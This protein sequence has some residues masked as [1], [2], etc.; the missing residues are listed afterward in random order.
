MRKLFSESIDLAALRKMVQSNYD[1]SGVPIG[2]IDAVS[3]EVYAGAGWQRICTDYH[4]KHPETLALCVESDTEISGKIKRGESLA[5][6]CK[7]GLWDIGIP[8]MSEGEH[9]VTIFLGQ[10]RYEDEIIDENLFKENARRYEFPIEEYLAA[11]KEVPVFTREKVE[12]IISYNKSFA[13]FLSSQIADKIKYKREAQ[14][15]KEA[16]SMHSDLFHN[17]TV[18]VVYQDKSGGIINANKA[19]QEILGLSLEQMQGRSSVDPR[20]QTIY[21]DGSAFPGEKHP[22]MVALKTGK[23]VN[24][25]V[26]GVFNPKDNKNHWLLVNSTPQF[27]ENTLEPYQV[28]T[29]FIDI[30]ERIIAEKNL[31][32]LNDTLENQ[33]EERTKQLSEKV[34]A[35]ELSENNF[36]K[37]V[38]NSP[39]ILYRFSG[40]KGGFFV[41]KRVETVLGYPA[42]Y[43]MDHPLIWSQSIH[44]EDKHLVDDAIEQAKKGRPFDIEYR[45]KDKEER[46]HW[47]RDRSI[48]VTTVGEE[49]TIEGLAADITERKSNEI[50]LRDI[51][52]KLEMANKLG[53][54]GWWEYD[55][56]NDS[57][58]WPEETYALYGLDPQKIELDYDRMMACI[59]PEY[60][61]YHNEQ[62]ERI[63]KDG[64]AEFIYPVL[65]PN[66]E[67]RWIWAKGEAEYDRE[68]RPISLF[69]TLQD[70]TERIRI[71]HKLRMQAQIIEQVHDSVI[72]VDLEGHIIAWNKG[73]EN[74]FQYSPDEVIGNHVSMVYPKEY[75]SKLEG[76]IIPDLLAEG[77]LE[78]E[79]NLLRKNGSLFYGLVSLSVLRNEE[80][81]VYGMVGYTIDISRRKEVEQKLQESETKFKTLFN[82]VAIPLCYVDDNGVI[83]DFNTKF[84]QVFGYTKSDIPTLEEWWEFAYPD[85]EYRKWVVGTWEKAV[86]DARLKNTDI[87]SV[88]YNVTCKNGDVRNVVISGTT[89]ENYFL[90]TFI[91]ITDRNKTLQEL[92]RSNKELEQFAY[93]A[94]HDLQEPMRTVIGFLQLLQSRHENQ[95]DGKA[96]H[97]IDRSIKA[98]HRMQRLITD[99]LTYSRTNTK[100]LTC[101][102]TDL[103]QV[104]FQVEE[105][106]KAIIKEKKVVLKYCELPCVYADKNQLESLFQ[107]LILNGIKY[108]QSATPEIEIGFQDKGETQLFYVKDNGIGISP[109]SHDKIFE[110]FHRLHSQKEYSGTGLGLALCKRI[111][112]R[113]GGK[114]WVK[115]EPGN[116]STFYF[117]IKGDN[118][119]NE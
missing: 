23:S 49:F 77:S 27:K 8:V 112:E 28:F 118:G 99:L 58:I 33:V 30:T 78:Y 41:S 13:E 67:K 114:I 96:L 53:K 22:S 20:W 69:G 61:D 116:G 104:I 109:K 19:S 89:L 39:E 5:Y 111:V 32:Q 97:Y 105:N 48:G 60:H 73:S 55:V 72:S 66:Q 16:E 14:Q 92:S 7:N 57:V 25:V 71:E 119:F 65:L 115:S 26:M 82:I 54:S 91:D 94:S 43:L 90:A 76:E 100:T 17:M 18:G 110:A 29:T 95:L 50:H 10:F 70:I 21:E 9:I 4:R 40:K 46:W 63:Y 80:G 75:H 98:G 87:K 56:E 81:E 3:G 45:I 83:L 42:S 79:A 64:E 68:G 6:K 88:E 84:T 52:K 1:A 106:L 108:N 113:Q 59:L 117:S 101:S 36:K 35:L 37:L 11:F 85:V 34:T 24:D 15:R 86:E 47:F 93:V 44:P 2:I 103:G 31:L 62:L 102:K 74:L 38:D 51:T 12:A 107:N